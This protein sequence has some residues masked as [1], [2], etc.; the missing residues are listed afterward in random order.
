MQFLDGFAMRN[1]HRRRH[2]NEKTVF[3]DAGHVAEGA[4]KAYR[5]RNLSEAAIQNV[6]TFV[7]EKGFPGGLAQGYGRAQCLDFL[8]YQPFGEATDFDW[9]R[10][11]AQDR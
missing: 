7:G 9:Y 11:R 2:V 5:I 1:Q 3:D 8:F 6:M 10:E 4:R